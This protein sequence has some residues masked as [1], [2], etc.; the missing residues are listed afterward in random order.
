MITPPTMARLESDQHMTTRI[1]THENVAQFIDHRFEEI[2]IKQ[3]LTRTRSSLQNMTVR[4]PKGEILA[5][6]KM[7]T[8]LDMSRQELLFELIGA[9]MEQA[10]QTAAS[11][12][13]EGPERTAWIDDM[14]STWTAHDVELEDAE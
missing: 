12:L 5:I 2:A 9:G 10:I 8:F 6:D 11:H 13:K 14:V 3:L 1:H 7:A 4:L